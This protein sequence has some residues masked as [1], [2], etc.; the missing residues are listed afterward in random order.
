VGAGAT[1][2]CAALARALDEPLPGTAP[3]APRWVCLEHRGTW[4]SD[5][6]AHRDG[7]VRAFLDRATAAGWRPLLVRRAGR[8]PTDG[9]TRVFLADTGPERPQVTVLRVVD[10]ADLA[11]AAER[12]MGMGDP[13][14]VRAAYH[15]LRQLIGAA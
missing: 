15:S 14:D 5:L 8:R 4:P 1:P 3:V 13:R 12:M 11:G 10:P 7:A 9:P 2:W 6:T